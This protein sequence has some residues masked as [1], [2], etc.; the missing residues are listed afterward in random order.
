MISF[1]APRSQRRE[2]PGLK[3]PVEKAS[4]YIVQHMYDKLGGKQPE[5]MPL[6][7]TFTDV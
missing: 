4:R 3:C 2:V 7:A 1:F 6:L 5:Y